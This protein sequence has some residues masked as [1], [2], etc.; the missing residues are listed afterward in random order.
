MFFLPGGGQYLVPFL[1]TVVVPMVA[2]GLGFLFL[3][4]VEM[5]PGMTQRPGD[6]DRFDH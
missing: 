2:L 1:L 6:G 3:Y 5:F 4:K